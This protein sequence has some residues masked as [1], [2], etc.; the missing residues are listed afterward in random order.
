ML[1]EVV[2]AF[3]DVIRSPTRVDVERIARELFL[4]VDKD[5]RSMTRLLTNML[6]RL[7]GHVVAV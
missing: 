6:S 7:D 2:N 3:L 1:E 5:L 4:L